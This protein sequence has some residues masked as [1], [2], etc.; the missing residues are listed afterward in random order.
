M[1]RSGAPRSITQSLTRFPQAA[2]RKAFVPT[3]PRAQ[4][5]SSSRSLVAKWPSTLAIAPRKP[6]AAALQRYASTSPGTA[7]DHIDQKREN[8]IAKTEIPADP[9]AVSTDSSVRQILSEK[10]VE[11][12]ETETD[13]LAGVKQDLV[14]T[15]TGSK[16]V[17]W[18]FSWP[19]QFATL[20]QPDALENHQGYLCVDRGTARSSV[21]WDGWCTAIPCNIPLNCLPCM[22]YQPCCA[23]WQRLPAIR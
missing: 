9:E 15:P 19:I 12:P 2:T 20:T 10:G 6:L 23:D 11:E 4:L 21:Y 22:G 7:F 18:T 5:T 1:I 13:M 3:V 17:D 16:G 14:R 8:K